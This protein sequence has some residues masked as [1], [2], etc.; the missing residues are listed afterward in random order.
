MV[1][2]LTDDLRNLLVQIQMNL[3]LDD[4]EKKLIARTEW[5]GEYNQNDRLWLND[6]RTRYKGV[7]TL[8]YNF[9]QKTIKR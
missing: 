7:K 9:T 6:L 2:K 4:E 8:D 1:Y 3:I 5:M